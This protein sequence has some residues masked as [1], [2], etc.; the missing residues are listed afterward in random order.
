MTDPEEWV[1]EEGKKSVQQGCCL[2]WFIF[3]LIPFLI[4]MA[5]FIS[6]WADLIFG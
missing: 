3:I 4:M 6:Y 1:V 2:M 5:V